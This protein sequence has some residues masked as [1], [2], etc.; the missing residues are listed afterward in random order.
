MPAISIIVAADQ[1]KAIGKNNS[2]PWHLPNDLKFFKNKTMGHH[3]IMG[4][5][6][7]ESIG[8]ALPGRISVVKSR[9][10]KFTFNDK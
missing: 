6:T 3:M 7:L 8:K 4:R 1:N 5:K 9:Q 10:K 2:L